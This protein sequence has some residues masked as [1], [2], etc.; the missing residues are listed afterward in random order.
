MFILLVSCNSN[1][2]NNQENYY[3]M[4]K[5]ITGET[6]YNRIFNCIEDSLDN[7]KSKN[8]SVSYN[9]KNNFKLLFDSLICLNSEG[10]KFLVGLHMYTLLNDGSSDGLIF[11]NGI[12]IENNWYL[13]R[14]PSVVIPREMFKNHPINQP[15]SY[16]QL[17]EMA[18]KNVYK[19]YLKADG[20]INDAMINH[21]F[22]KNENDFKTRKE[23]ERYYLALSKNIWLERYFPYSSADFKTSYDA[24]TKELEVSFPLKTFDS[25]NCPPIKY[26][27]LY[28]YEGLGYIGNI[29]IN[30]FSSELNWYKSP[31]INAVIKDIPD[32]KEIKLYLEVLHYPDAISP[33]YGPF[34]VK[35]NS[36]AQSVLN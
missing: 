10:D 23:Y 35:S 11:F 32:N 29:F 14:G 21:Y 6:S 5:S 4:S 36:K 8:V 3:S 30:D 18:L 31:V 25:I 13:L 33:R 19:G 1:N 15:L 24:V 28:E 22:P 12:K 26:K 27:L 9:N 7:W 17:H 20:S 34:M 2:T 16:Q